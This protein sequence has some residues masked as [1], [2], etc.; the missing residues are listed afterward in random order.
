M[1]ESICKWKIYVRE[2]NQIWWCN[3][4]CKNTLINN[5]TL[6]LELPIWDSKIKTKI[7]TI[8]NNNNK[9]RHSKSI[10]PMRR[11][12]R[13]LSKTKFEKFNGIPVIKQDKSL[14]K[15]EWKIHKDYLSLSKDKKQVWTFFYLNLIWFLKRI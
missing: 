1:Q 2:E 15:K 10:Q 11:K 4:N 12:R 7:P 3:F 9:L 14:F 5:K 13:Q 8:N 6:I